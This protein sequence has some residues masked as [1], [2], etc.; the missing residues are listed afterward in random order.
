MQSE[1]DCDDEED[2]GHNAGHASGNGNHGGFDT[3]NYLSG[4]FDSR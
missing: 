3:P 2:Y 4:D 1:S